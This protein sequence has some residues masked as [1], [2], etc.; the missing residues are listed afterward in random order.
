MSVT[1]LS[2]HPYPYS[3]HVQTC[4]TRA[5]PAAA[6]CARGV[7]LAD[8]ANASAGLLALIQQLRF[9]HA[10]ASVEHGFSHPRLCQSG[11]THV[12]YNDG[13][14]L[15]NDLPRIL[16]LGIFASARCRAMQT[17]RLALMASP[18][19]LGDLQLDVAVKVPRLELLAIA[20]RHGVF[21]PKIE[22]HRVVLGD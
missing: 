12:P 19:C 5:G 10:P 7:S 22:P 4:G 20:R 9:E 21:E 14:I 11:A 13:L 3:A 8:D 16:M 15:I 1:T 18:L 6:A 17:L 2:A